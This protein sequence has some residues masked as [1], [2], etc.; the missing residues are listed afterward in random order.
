MKRDNLFAASSLS[1]LQ[2]S[3]VILLLTLNATVGSANPQSK[4]R[5]NPTRLTTNVIS[6]AISTDNNKDNYH[7]SFVAGPGEVTITLTVESGSG[8]VSS[9]GFDL[10]DE[11]AKKIAGKYVTASGGRSEQ[12]VERVN[13]T[14]RQPLLLRIVVASIMGSGSYRL[15]LSGVVDSSQD[16]SS[17]RDN[18]DN[19]ECLPKRG[20]LR[21]KMKDGSVRR[22]DLGEAEEITIEH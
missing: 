16:R 3:A 11:D 17:S 18:T 4:D 5:D 15:R 22:I 12:V 20:I 13:V 8:S 14:R 9:T 10:Y 7:Y 2:K 6:G 21:V 1:V 19:P